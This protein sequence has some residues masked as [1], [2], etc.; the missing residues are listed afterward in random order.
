MRVGA[1]A[2]IPLGQAHIACM[3][4]LWAREQSID[5]SNS[6]S[7]RPVSLDPD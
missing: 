6:K 5:K 7:K 4:I 1:M 2:D 3:G